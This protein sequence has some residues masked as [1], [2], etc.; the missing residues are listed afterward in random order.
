MTTP[1]FV[2]GGVRVVVVGG[3]EVDVGG[4]GGFNGG[5][6]GIHIAGEMH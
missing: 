3:E 6:R 5:G 4:G 2:A 1:E